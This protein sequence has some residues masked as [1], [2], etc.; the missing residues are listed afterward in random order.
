L[1]KHSFDP[2]HALHRAGHQGSPVGN[3]EAQG[4]GGDPASAFGRKLSQETFASELMREARQRYQ[5]CVKEF[6]RKGT[7]VSGSL[8]LPAAKGRLWLRK[9][10]SV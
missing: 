10:W 8:P 5:S 7:S 2:K 1:L 3:Y 9:F 4:G 6:Q